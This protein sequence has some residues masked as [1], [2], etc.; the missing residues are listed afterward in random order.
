VV[1]RAKIVLV[2][3]GG[4]ALGSY[5]GGAYEG[6]E[7]HGVAVDWIVGTSI[8]AINGGI[9]AGNRPEHRTKALRAFWETV[10]GEESTS[11]TGIDAFTWLNP[12]LPLSRNYSILTKGIRG[13]FKPLPMDPWSMLNVSS[14]P[15]TSFYDTSPL[16]ETLH[17]HVDFGYL[18]S[19]KVR[20]SVS[21][22]NVAT[23]ELER[24]DN[25]GGQKISAAHLLASGAL[26]PGFPA[27]EISGQQYWDGG[28]YSNTPIDY[29]LDDAERQDTLCFMVDLWDPTEALPTSLSEVM[30][31]Q[32]NIQYASRS[33]GHVDDHR[34]MQN[35]RRT[36]QQLAEHVPAAKRN[37][38]EVKALADQGCSSSINIVRLIMKALPDDDHLKDIDFSAA[39]LKKRWAAGQND[40]ARMFKH[41]QWLT[42]LPAGVGMAIH[43]LAQD[44]KND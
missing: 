43:E 12:W 14:S 44:D 16:A 37:S 39:T 4:G 6:L 38:R 1:K 3:Q 21:A 27:V 31:R 23:G 10:T 40:V 24:F 32:K 8:G 17:K 42:P 19:G 41:K 35:L 28:I 22:V 13:F 7:Q 9:I 29:V 18:N 2:L 26:P 11:M 5:Q 30:T 36:I 34:R 25:F 33:K 15:R 20:L